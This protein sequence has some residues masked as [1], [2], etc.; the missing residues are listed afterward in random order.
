MLLGTLFISNTAFSASTCIRVTCSASAI[1]EYNTNMKSDTTTATTPVC[2]RDSSGSGTEM[3]FPN[4]TACKSGYHVVNG[5]SSHVTLS[6]IEACSNAG[7][8]L[9]SINLCEKECKVGTDCNAECYTFSNSVTGGSY[10][11]SCEC[12]YRGNWA[13]GSF[14]AACKHYRIFKITCNDQYYGDRTVSAYDG[15]SYNINCTK[16]PVVD[17]STT[18]GNTKS[19]S[20]V[21]TQCYAPKDKDYSS[22]TGTFHFTSDC[23]YTK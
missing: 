18:A 13:Y 3:I 10:Q 19:G 6:G 21:I 16:C 14:A 20:T 12:H 15:D 7:T 1:N 17:P 5:A 8:I 2:I 22:T 4:D 11:H 9:Q 23:Y